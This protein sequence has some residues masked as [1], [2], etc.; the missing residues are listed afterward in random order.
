MPPVNITS[1]IGPLEVV[2]VHTPGKELEAVTPGNREDYLYDDLIGLEVSAR[3]HA[4]LT[5]GLR[6]FARVQA[7]TDL[8]VV[9]PA[10]GA[11]PVYV[12]ARTIN[13]V[14][15]TARAQERA[16]VVAVD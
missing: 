14:P 4:R 6:Q 15:G 8:L 11:A 13:V 3:E 12:L 9:G 7:I 1:E 16:P 10:G 2:L 5:A